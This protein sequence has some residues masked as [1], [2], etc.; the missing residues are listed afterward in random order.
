MCTLSTIVTPHAYICPSGMPPHNMTN[1]VFPTHEVHDGRGDHR[2]IP[3]N[4][5][6]M[7]L[8]ACAIL[9]YDQG[10]LHQVHSPLHPP[11]PMHHQGRDLGTRHIRSHRCHNQ[12][13]LG[14]HLQVKKT[15]NT[16][17]HIYVR[18]KEGKGGR[19]GTA[20]GTW[21]AGTTAFAKLWAP[22]VIMA[23]IR[24]VIKV[25]LARITCTATGVEPY[26]Y[27]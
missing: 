14:P 12:K 15:I 5:T 9:L 1:V 20:E 18:L 17:L 11:L 26:Y 4:Y 7:H 25:V 10:M 27:W 2:G 23:F 8:A 22:L 24:W 19:T 6:N 3:S 21:R 16:M 13:N